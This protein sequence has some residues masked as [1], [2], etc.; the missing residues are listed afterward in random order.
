MKAADVPFATGA[1]PC[2]AVRFAMASAPY[3]VHACHCRD[4][5][6]LTGSAFA[7][8]AVIETDRLALLAGTVLPVSHP[9]P[10][11]RGQIVLRCNEC[12]GAVWSHYGS[13]GDKAAFVRT[14]T[15]DSPEVCAPHVHIYTRT[16]LPWITLPTGIPAFEAFYGG[17][18]IPL[19]YGAEGAARLA[20][21]R[22]RMV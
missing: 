8:N 16:R 12:Q 14:G 18:D 9:T 19:I 3:V 2:G 5:Q 10:S 11:G 21:L 4:C 15:L 22:A 6:R 7:S 13:M 17:R 20:A 1:C